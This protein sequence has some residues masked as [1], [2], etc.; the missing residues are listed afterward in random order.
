MGPARA[1]RGD[2]STLRHW[3]LRAVQAMQEGDGGEGLKAFALA[4]SSLEPIERD[5]LVTLLARDLDDL[6]GDKRGRVFGLMA[7]FEP[8]DDLRGAL[9]SL[10]WPSA[11]GLSRVRPRRAG[12]V[13]GDDEV[14]A[15]AIAVRTAEDSGWDLHA[16]RW[17]QGVA[18]EAQR[19]AVDHE[20][21]AA[22]L[23]DFA[24]EEG[25]RATHS[26]EAANTL[27]L[28]LLRW[29]RRGGDAPS[30]PS[31]AELIATG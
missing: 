1:D 7:A 9:V 12:Y 8:D 21:V 13:M 4:Y 22:R 28:P 30:L 6:D 16:L 31:L 19:W 23:A 18:F 10:A 27:S 17:A 11:G 2:P 14:G 3:L 5:Q 25:W 20:G 26:V 29:L 15:A 24:G